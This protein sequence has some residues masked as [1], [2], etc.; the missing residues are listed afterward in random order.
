[1]YTGYPKAPEVTVLDHSLDVPVRLAAGTDYKL[2]YKNN[3]N[4]STERKYATVSITGK[5]NYTGT[6]NTSF[7]ILKNTFSDSQLLVYPKIPSLYYNGKTQKAEIIV[8]DKLTQEVLKPQTAYKL[9]YYNMKEP[10]TATVLITPAGSGWSN[11]TA[12]NKPM[13]STQYEILPGDLSDSAIVSI[14]AIKRQKYKGKAI[15]P[16]PIVKVNGR[17]LKQGVDYQVEY[18]NHTGI[19]RP[20]YRPFLVIR[21]I[22]P[23]YTGSSEKMYFDIY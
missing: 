2:T 8:Y 14:K 3:T 20:D 23:R 6:V 11:V 18:T 1:I 21:G 9:T 7:H 19:S 17:L 10:G 22:G 4:P 15:E 12:T 13:L 16:K 5:G